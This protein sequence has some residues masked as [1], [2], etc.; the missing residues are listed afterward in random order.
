MAD[1]VQDALLR[2]VDALYM[3]NIGSTAAL[4]N[5][6]GVQTQLTKAK[7]TDWSS[8][9]SVSTW[10]TNL[11]D[12]RQSKKPAMDYIRLGADTINGNEG[13]D[14]VVGDNAHVMPIVSGAG[15]A[16]VGSNVRILPI[17]EPGATQASV[18]RYSYDWGLYGKLHRTATADVNLKSIYNIDTDKIWGDAGNDVLFGLQGD[19]EVRGGDGDD[20]VSGGNGYDIVGGGAGKNVVAFDR[21]RDK[22]EQTKGAK[23]SVKQTVDASADSK[24]LGRGW[25]SPMFE[26]LGKDVN[27]AAATGLLFG[28]NAS[29]VITPGVQGV[30]QKT[31]EAA[32]RPALKTPFTFVATVPPPTFTPPVLPPVPDVVAS[33]HSAQPLP[34]DLITLLK[35]SQI[36]VTAN[37]E[38]DL[39]ARDDLDHW[40]YDNIL[41]KFVVAPPSF[42]RQSGAMVFDEESGGFV[43][44]D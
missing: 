38:D 34:A 9:G 43:P 22:A 44:L 29:A 24:I 35:T 37:D 23:D 26:A 13:S 36:T 32:T 30:V 17:G 27:R 41:S 2:T 25:L 39:D 11:S 6:F 42:G 15:T 20:T 33:Y 18:L 7:Q 12:P 4:A 8:N 31:I 19:D 40:I 28:K 3:G 16:G 1:K 5:A 10:L 14:I 21:P